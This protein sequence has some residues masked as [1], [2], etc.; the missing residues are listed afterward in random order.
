RRGDQVKTL[1]TYFAANAQG[2]NWHLAPWPT[3]RFVRLTPIADR[4]LTGKNVE[5]PRG[6]APPGAP[7]TVHDPLESHGSR[8]SAVA[9]AYHPV[10]KEM[11]IR[12]AKAAH[13]LA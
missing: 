13:L 10:P 12:T 6:I 4:G 2:R 8:C 11:T 9:M 3:K 5:S 1:H 7:K